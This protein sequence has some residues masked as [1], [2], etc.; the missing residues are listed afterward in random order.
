MTYVTVGWEDYLL[1][2]RLLGMVHLPPRK[3]VDVSL[4][5]AGLLFF[6]RQTGRRVLAD[7]TRA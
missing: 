1:T 3:P 7:G 6:D 2:S 4:D 5:P